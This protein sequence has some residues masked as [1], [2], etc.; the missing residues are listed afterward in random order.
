M[1]LKT[2]KQTVRNMCQDAGVLVM[3]LALGMFFLFHGAQKLFGV[4]EGL[5]L[6]G[7]ASLIETL[8]LPFPQY[9]SVAIAAAEFFGGALL[10]LGIYLRTAASL[11]AITMF[12]SAYYVYQ[13][14]VAVYVEPI[15]YPLNPG[16]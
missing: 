1:L 4:C 10:V 7:F 11:L 3:R 5:G 13:N 12:A 2:V 15:S 8:Q 14:A 6:G 9:L 16:R